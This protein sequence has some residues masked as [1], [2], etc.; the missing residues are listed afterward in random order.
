MGKFAI[1]GV[2]VCAA[3]GSAVAGPNAAPA[4]KVP[5]AKAAPMVK[6]IDRSVLAAMAAKAKEQARVLPRSRSR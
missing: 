3:A 6:R 2:L 4:A 1:I 5:A